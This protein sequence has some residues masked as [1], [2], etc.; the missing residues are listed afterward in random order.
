MRTVHIYSGSLA[1]VSKSGVG[2]AAKH[3]HAALESV[4]VRVVT[5]WDRRAGVV[6][7]NTVLP[8]SLCG[9]A[10]PPP[11]AKGHLVRSLDRERLSQFLHRLQPAGTDF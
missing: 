1:L 2:Q 10:C 11:G 7:I 5:T 8:V 3:Q 4:G 9:T 6:H